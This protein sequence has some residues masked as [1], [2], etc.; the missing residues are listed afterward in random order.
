MPTK[1]TT[2]RNTPSTSDPK[3]PGGTVARDHEDP[4]ELA[5][6]NADLELSSIP[7]VGTSQAPVATT[8]AIPGPTAIGPRDD[9]VT[10]GSNHG[11]DEDSSSPKVHYM[12]ETEWS[13]MHSILGKIKANFRENAKVMEETRSLHQNAQS[14]FRQ[15]EEGLERQREA[16]ARNKESETLMTSFMES[17]SGRKNPE[18]AVNKGKTAEGRSAGAPRSIRLIPGTV[19]R[20]IGN[21]EAEEPPVRSRRD[22]EPSQ[23]LYPDRNLEIDNDSRSE[24]QASPRA[25]GE[26]IRRSRTS[27][28]DHTTPNLERL[29][30]DIIAFVRPRLK[31]D[32]DSESTVYSTHDSL[33]QE[34]DYWSN[35]SL[36]AAQRARR[37]HEV[38]LLTAEKWLETQIEERAPQKQ[39]DAAQAA[40]LQAKIELNRLTRLSEADLMP[41]PKSIDRA[42]RNLPHGTV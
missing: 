16:E 15:T 37:A 38:K 34:A 12:N 17:V 8:S 9:A 21:E 20:E 39:L 42:Y 22:V 18:D 31:S 36:K 35:V 28:N 13:Y 29:G 3:E 26:A 1:R 2:R 24:G 32:I 6:P 7:K 14:L 11:E 5:N 27:M 30:D 25:I 4:N 33:I 41:I 19:P 10:L 23:D 40:V